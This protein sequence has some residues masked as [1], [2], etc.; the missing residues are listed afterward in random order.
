MSSARSPP[1]AMRS[2]IATT[3]TPSTGSSTANRTT[4]WQA[5]RRAY[6]KR[7][8]R[9]IPRL[10]RAETFDAGRRYGLYGPG[11]PCSSR[12]KNSSKE[13]GSAI[14]SLSTGPTRR[15]PRIVRLYRD[16]VRLRLNREGFTRGLCGQFTQVY[17]LHDVRKVIAFHRWDKGGPADDVVV[18]ANF[19]HEPQDD[20]VIGFPVAGPGSSVSTAIGRV[21]AKPS[22]VM[23][24]PMWFPNR[25]VRWPTLPC[26][27]F[28]GS[29]QC[30]DLFAMIA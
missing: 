7:S 28:D 1:S 25:R 3:T 24:A 13:G 12:V 16:L 5:A 20:Y 14:R 15:V 23:R 2:V 11:I 27:A 6:R 18:I 9:R 21:T 26:R 8:I 4:R 22:K 17:H 10:V 30:A 19:L 29:L